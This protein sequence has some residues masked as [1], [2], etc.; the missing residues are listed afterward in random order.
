MGQCRVK[1]ELESRYRLQSIIVRDPNKKISNLTKV[2]KDIK[3]K[4]EFTWP[5]SSTGLG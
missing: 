5:F 4:T 2:E 1:Q 3:I